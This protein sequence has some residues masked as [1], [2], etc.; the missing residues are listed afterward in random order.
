MATRP[1]KPRDYFSK[2]LD[3]VEEEIDY[4]DIP[5]T[6]TGDWA[7]AEVL[8]PV[9]REEFQAIKRFISAR[10]ARGESA[11]QPPV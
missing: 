5:A 3:V 8:L 1:D 7:S 9:T 6:S 2:L 11:P 4:S 10:R